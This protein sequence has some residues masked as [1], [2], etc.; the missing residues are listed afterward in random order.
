MKP[1]LNTLPLGLL[2]GIIAPLIIFLIFYFMK[3]SNASFGEYINILIKRDIIVQIISLCVIVNLGLFFLFIQ[4]HRYYSA[5]GI[6]MATFLY[7]I[8]IVLFK[9]I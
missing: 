6:I 9:F 3:F 1:N 4:T 7:A 8:G 2:T 5:R